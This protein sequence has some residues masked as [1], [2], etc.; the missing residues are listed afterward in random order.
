MAERKKYKPIKG[1]TP[2]KKKLTVYVTM[3]LLQ[4]VNRDA[5]HQNRNVSNVI[6]TLL[7]N[8]YLGNTRNLLEEALRKRLNNLD[9]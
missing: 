8:H 9:K 2:E 7:N 5:E 4:A 6:E 1:N 3:D